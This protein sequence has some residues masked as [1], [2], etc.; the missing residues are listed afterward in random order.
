V[1]K[2]KRQ[3]HLNLFMMSTGHHEA[4]WR[5][6][7]AEPARHIDIRYFQD[8]AETAERAK[9]DSLFLADGLSNYGGSPYSRQGGLE[10]FTLLSALASVTRHIGLIGTVSTTYNEPF[11]VARKFASLDHISNG[12]AGWNIVTSA[13]EQSAFNFSREQHLEHS[14][15]YSRA[16]EFLE[17]TTKLWDSWEDE[18]PVRDKE[19][20][21]YADIEKI[22]AID[23]KGEWFSVKG[24]LNVPRPPQGY[25]LLVQA[26]SS[27]SGKSFAGRWA[28]AIFTAQQTLE[29]AQEFYADVKARADHY[30]RRAEEVQIL[31]GFSPVIGDTH[32]E[33]VDKEGRLHDLIAPERALTQFSRL[34]KLDLFSYPLDSPFPELPPAEQ[35]NGSQSRYKLIRDLIDREKPTIRELIHRLAGGR[36]HRTFAGT[37]IEV[38]DALEEWFTLGAADGFNI[39]PALLPDGLRDF[40]DKVVP[41]LQRRGLFRTEY[42]GQ[43]LRENYGLERPHNQFTL[44]NRSEI[45]PFAIDTVTERQGELVTS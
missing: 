21:I 23:H 37:P 44:Q 19:T 18:A 43:T 42:T 9:L 39:M 10:P 22:R 11:H 27:E 13:D 34:F 28:E 4:S 36:G 25:P 12:R 20:G 5:H 24:P 7:D 31:P 40:A 38:A 35:V 2:Q 16:N 8:L 1:S 6:P 3:L 29:E 26:G 30:G 45:T 15:R 14:S 17:V 41:E 33:A 32:A